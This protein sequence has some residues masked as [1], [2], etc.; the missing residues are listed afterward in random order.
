MHALPTR[1]RAMLKALHC[2]LRLTA[3]LSLRGKERATRSGRTVG[4]AMLQRF[5]LTLLQSAT[6]DV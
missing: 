1:L 3:L 2:A 5:T 4:R 6:F